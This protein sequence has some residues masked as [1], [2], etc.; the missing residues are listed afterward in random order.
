MLLDD[1]PRGVEPPVAAGEDG[2]DVGDVVVFVGRGE[3]RDEA[4]RRGGRR[5][6]GRAAGGGGCDE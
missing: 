6:G 5:P 2:V 3:L 1:V 4:E